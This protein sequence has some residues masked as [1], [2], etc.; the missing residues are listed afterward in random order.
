[1]LPP[2]MKRYREY[3]RRI[4][5]NCYM[6]RIQAFPN[7]RYRRGRAM[8]VETILSIRTEYAEGGSSKRGPRG[9]GAITQKYLA[10]RYHVSSSAIY[11]IIT[12]VSYKDKKYW[13]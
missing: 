12:G 9:K 8:S 1:M 4:Y 3:R 6:L 13:P 11:Q 7:L 2:R 10:D 5:K